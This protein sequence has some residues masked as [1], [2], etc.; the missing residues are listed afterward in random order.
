MG[1]ALSMAGRGYGGSPERYRLTEYCIVP[2]KAY[3]VAGTCVE[4]PRPH[5]VQDRN[6]I[7]NCENESNF[8][9]SDESRA[10]LQNALGW[11]TAKYI[12]GGAALAVASAALVL[13]SIG[14]LQSDFLGQ[15]VK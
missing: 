15:L 11:Q 5:N 1:G 6:L 7:V 14:W 4:N 3:T 9:I 12:L 8:L 13:Q 10:D 2:E